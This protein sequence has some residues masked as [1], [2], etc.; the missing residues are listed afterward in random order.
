MQTF[1]IALALTSSL[2][3]AE[4]EDFAA[5]LLEDAREHLADG[6]R[7]ELARVV[8]ARAAPRRCRCAVLRAPK[9]LRAPA[10]GPPSGTAGR[11]RR[12]T[13]AD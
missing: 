10:H 4:A 13:R 12:A 11:A 5:E 7:L 3:E 9:P 1:T 6:E 2:S 8:L